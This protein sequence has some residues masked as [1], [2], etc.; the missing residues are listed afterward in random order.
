REGFPLSNRLIREIHAVL[1]SRGRGSGKEPGEFRRSQNWIGGTR[2]GDASFVPPPS[3]AVPDYMTALERFLH[4]DAD[5]L[6]VIVRAGLSHVKS[7]PSPPFLEGSGRV[8]SL[9]IP[10]LLCRGGVLREPLL[11]LSLHLKQHREE[12]YALLDTVRR[13]GDWEAWLAFFLEGVRVT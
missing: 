1:L 8:G 3:D 11:Y 6:S 4:D 5:G 2:P 10:F 7:E 12:Y 13:D 9:L